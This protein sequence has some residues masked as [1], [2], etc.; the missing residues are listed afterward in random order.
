MSIKRANR[1]IKIKD[2]KMFNKA[3]R[4][5]LVRLTNHNLLN[6][7]EKVKKENLLPKIFWSNINQTVL[8]KKSLYI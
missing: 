2:A 4:W 6:N 3:N 5:D 8:S 1:M 7:K